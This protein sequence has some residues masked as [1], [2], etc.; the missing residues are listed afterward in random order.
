MSSGGSNVMRGCGTFL[1]LWTVWALVVGI[2]FYVNL[3]AQEV[4][5]RLQASGYAGIGSGFFMAF[6]S[7]LVFEVRRRFR[8]VTLLR[9][10]VAGVPP[11]DGARIAAYGTLVADGPL[12]E[13]PMTG[14]RAAIY[15]YEI[16]ARRKKSD[17]DAICSGY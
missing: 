3:P 14:A 10:S 17:D 8:E 12:L 15:K 7:S 1:G 13:A 6:A 9:D 5:S 2:F 4:G 16:M 11:T